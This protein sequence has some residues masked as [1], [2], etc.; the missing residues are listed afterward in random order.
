MVAGVL[1]NQSIIISLHHLRACLHE[2]RYLHHSLQ[3]VSWVGTTPQSL[4]MNIKSNNPQHH[5]PLPLKRP[6]QARPLLPTLH[7]PRLRLP[8]NPSRRRRPL[9]AIQRLLRHRREPRPRRSISASRRPVHFHRPQCP[10]RFPLCSRR[11]SWQGFWRRVGQEVQNI[12]DVH[13][14]SDPGDFCAVCLQDL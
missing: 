8:G 9:N 12:R 7:P 6:V 5:A 4:Q 1:A 3:E 10:V 11:P 14:P 13:Q 2:R